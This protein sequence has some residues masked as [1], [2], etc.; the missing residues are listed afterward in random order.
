M[1]VTRLQLLACVVLSLW[2]SAYAAPQT[3]AKDAAVTAAIEIEQQVELV[4]E[5]L[6]RGDLD[7][8][9]L[10]ARQ[11]S[12]AHPR[13][14][15]GHWLHAELS[16]LSAM[17]TLQVDDMH[18]WS[19]GAVSLL[20]EA[21]T[22]LEAARHRTRQQA[23]HDAQALLPRSLVHLGDHISDAIVVDLSRSELMHFTVDQGHATLVSRHYASSGSAGFGK[24]FEGDRKTPLGVY[25]LLH[26]YSQ[27]SLP[28]LYG[29]GALTLDYPNALDQ[30]LGRT[31]S[32][33]WLHG[34]PQA[35]HNRGPWSSEGCVTMPNAYMA[36]LAER[37]D[38]DRTLVVLAENADWIDATEQRTLRDQLRSAALRYL[39]PGHASNSVERHELIQRDITSSDVSAFAIS[40]STLLE[41]PDDTDSTHIAWW[42]SDSGAGV[43]E[44]NFLPVV[45]ELAPNTLA[46][47]SADELAQGLPEKLGQSPRQALPGP[48]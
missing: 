39:N 12:D 2:S 35:N 28:D 25:R 21:R 15:L 6:A 13:F 44:V 1:I 22:R 27:A 31:G 30:S 37:V 16:A 43:R 5:V 10:L 38:L 36:Q 9:S 34:V 3:A 45:P 26:H 4:L 29:D 23:A 8:A 41:V 40:R 32:G 46:G 17:D 48:L 7:D 42:P 11:L 33:I 14:R 24:R 20:L 47:L 18:D 19:T